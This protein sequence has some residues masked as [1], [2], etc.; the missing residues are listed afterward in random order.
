MKGTGF[1]GTEKVI[2][3]EDSQAVS[4]TKPSIDQ[5]QAKMFQISR[6]DTI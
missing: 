5:K 2:P 3:A 1:V 4:G 6:A